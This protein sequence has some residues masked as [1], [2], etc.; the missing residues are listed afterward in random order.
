MDA[1]LIVMLV[2]LGIFLILAIVGLVVLGLRIR[3]TYQAVKTFQQKLEWELTGLEQKQKLAMERITALQANTQ[4]IQEHSQALALNLD[5]VS[6]LF[7]EFAAAQER[8]KSIRT[9]QF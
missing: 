6:F 3:A 8:I 2:C 7:K 4:V 1:G 5:R 9:L